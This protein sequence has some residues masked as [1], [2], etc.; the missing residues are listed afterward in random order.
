MADFLGWILNPAVL[1]CIFLICPTVICIIKILIR[2][3][4]RRN[5]ET[6]F[7][8]PFS[9]IIDNCNY[10]PGLCINEM[11]YRNI[12]IT[13]SGDLYSGQDLLS[14]TYNGTNFTYSEVE[15]ANRNKNSKFKNKTI[16]FKGGV[17]IFDAP[18]RVTGRIVILP[19]AEFFEKYEMSKPRGCEKIE[20]ENVVFNE[21]FNVYTTNTEEAFYILTPQAMEK[22]I[23]LF[24]NSG[25]KLGINIMG[26]KLA[27]V[28]P[29][30][31]LFKSAARKI[32][33]PNVIKEITD[34]AVSDLEELL[35]LIETFKDIE[36]KS[37]EQI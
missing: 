22:I 35:S 23:S 28:I 3:A 24:N 26:D 29:Q 18:K 8:E 10:A 21:N 30:L 1:V 34:N 6:W 31:D 15:A 36:G 37:A 14:G 12:G 19:K 13:K 17:F 32:K 2:R 4:E 5:K 11:D 27:V 20:M 33:D 9:K 7:T 16:L 25:Y